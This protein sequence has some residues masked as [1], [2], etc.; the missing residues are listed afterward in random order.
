MRLRAGL[1]LGVLAAGAVVYVALSGSEDG[2]SGDVARSKRIAPV[3]EATCSTAAQ[4]SPR[5]YAKRRCTPT[6]A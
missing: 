2:G 6:Y 3:V 1:L 4:A 5:R